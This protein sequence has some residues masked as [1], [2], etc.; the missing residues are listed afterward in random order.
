MFSQKTAQSLRKV[1]A[2]EM[3]RHPLLGIVYCE[4]LAEQLTPF[5]MEQLTKIT[6]HSADIN[7]AR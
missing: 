4:E 2:N 7:H 1:N 6:F 3:R 5:A